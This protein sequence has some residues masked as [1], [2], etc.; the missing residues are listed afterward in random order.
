MTGLRERIRQAYYR[1]AGGQFNARALLR[2]VR[3]FLSDID[4]DALDREGKGA[5]RRPR[6]AP[7]G[8]C[9]QQSDLQLGLG[10]KRG[11]P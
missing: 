2:D 6:W 1:A 4:R 5:E 11:G 10:Q 9:D 8:D 3:S 7:F